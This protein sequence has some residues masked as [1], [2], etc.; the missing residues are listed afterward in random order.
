LAGS[1]ALGQLFLGE[2]SRA[3]EL[4]RPSTLDSRTTASLP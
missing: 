4:R 3:K 2:L 1:E